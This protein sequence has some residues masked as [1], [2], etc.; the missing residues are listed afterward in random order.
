[1]KRRAVYR[2]GGPAVD[3]VAQ[4]GVAD[5][6][7]VHPDLMSPTRA[8]ADLEQGIPRAHFQPAKLADRLAAS[9]DHC[10]PLPLPG[11]TPDRRL[12]PG[13]RFGHLANHDRTVAPVHRPVLELAGEVPVGNIVASDH[14]QPRGVAVEPVNDPGP[15]D[16]ADRRPSRASSKQPVHQGAGGM[17]RARVHH[18]ARRLVYHEQVVVL[19][20]HPQSHG[21]GCQQGRL[22]RWD[23][24]GEL[25]PRVQASPGLAGRTVHQD[26][27]LPN[28]PLHLAPA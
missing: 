8:Q 10:H 12:D 13:R 14:Q 7:K 25:I 27:S 5:I 3:A 22:A 26:E 18:E 23:L 11:I 9:G 6:G 20:D 24:P 15:V 21:L 4:D 17:S 1:M 19:E 28:Q 16:T 2:H